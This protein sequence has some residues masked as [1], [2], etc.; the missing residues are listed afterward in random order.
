MPYLRIGGIDLYSEDAGEG[1]PVLLM[2]GGFCS[3]ESLRPQADALAAGHH[4]FAYE[5]PGHGR[6]ADVDGEYHYARDVDDTLAYLDTQGLES[7]HIV[8]YSDGAIIGLLLALGHPG[9]VRSLVTISGNL[10]PSAF[11]LP[12]QDPAEGSAPGSEAGPCAR[13]LTALPEP[14]EPAPILERDWYARLS[15]DGS[16]HADVVLEKLARLWRREPHIPAGE[17]ARV[18]IPVLV[19]AAD[20]DMVRPDH[21]LLMAASFP[22]GQLC[23][24]PGVSHRLVVERPELVSQILLDF[25]ARQR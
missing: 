8:G 19:L 4:V 18:T 21:S 15:P 16:G 25:L 20:H 14:A 6:S 12:G 23:I 17:L 7:V 2:H 1:E 22:R 10:D 5:R 3:L 11:T 24:L 9:R 13:V